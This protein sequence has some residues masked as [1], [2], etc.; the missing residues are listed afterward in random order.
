MQLDAVGI[1]QEREILEVHPVVQ[2]AEGLY[3]P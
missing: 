1:G 3:S 2:P